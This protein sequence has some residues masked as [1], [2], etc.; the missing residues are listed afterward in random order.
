MSEDQDKLFDTLDRLLEAIGDDALSLVMHLN[1]GIETFRTQAV[2]IFG[3]MLIVTLFW[4]LVLSVLRPDIVG[5]PPYYLMIGIYAALVPL[6]IWL[7]A[8][9][10]LQYRS[11]R[12][13]YARMIEA[14]KRFQEAKKHGGKG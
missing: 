9:M 13:R 4:Y 12:A 14:A 1:E 3:Y 8:K 7:E 2:L 10:I 11:Y 6:A 5:S